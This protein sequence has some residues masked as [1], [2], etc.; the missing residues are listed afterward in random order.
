[1]VA[2]QIV[3]RVTI[4]GHNNDCMFKLFR[5][6][7]TTQWGHTVSYV[8]LVT[9]ATHTHQAV[10]SVAV[11][12]LSHPTSMLLNL[13]FKRNRNLTLTEMLLF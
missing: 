2:P 6:A 3:S 13:N 11:L 7:E 12:D 5:T 10:T 9:M 4:Y 8:Y 1:M